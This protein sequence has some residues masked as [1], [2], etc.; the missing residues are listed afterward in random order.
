MNKRHDY[1]IGDV[2]GC[3]AALQQLK[4]LIEFDERQDCL[5][6]A[7]DLVA[8][9]EDSL[10]TLR[11]VKRL[12][13]LG[14][15]KT[16]LGNHD[17]NLIGVWRGFAKLRKKDLTEP[18][19]NAP[20]AAELLNWLRQQ[21]LLLLP[22]ARTVLTHAGI[23]PIWTVQQAAG[24]AQEVEAVLRADLAV[25]DQFLCEMYGNQPDRWDADLMGVARLRVITN[26][27]TRMRLCTAS[28][29]LEFSFKDALEAEMPDGFLPWFDWQS[30]ER[31]PRLRLFG[32]WAALEGKL[33]S[34]DVM[35]LDGGCVWGGS[36]LAYRLSD[37]QVF[38]S[39]SG[40]AALL[41]NE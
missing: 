16:V 36:L 2:Q 3:F 6:F 17:L 37:G 1:I 35:P 32:H 27:L 28:G 39:S 38:K 12:S 7:G 21:P 41:H 8:R 22:D 10:S 24:Y 15:A 30:I 33:P 19:L 20:D 25:L 5:W 29:R 31:T 40:C 34:L 11:E 4:D 23:P 13:D 18:I 9:G 14:A 26:Y